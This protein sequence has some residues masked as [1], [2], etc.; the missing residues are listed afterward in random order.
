MITEI[1]QN[2]LF[3]NFLILAASL[4]ILVKAADLIVLGISNYARKF[5]ISEYLIGFLVVSIGMSS[6]EF[7]SSLMGNLQNNS[8]IVLGAFFGAV[9]S[10]LL[11]VVGTVAIFGRKISLE[12]RLLKESRHYLWVLA[13]V[14]VAFMLTGKIPR[15]G[16]GVLVS[17]FAAYV[18]YLW[19]REG[20]FGKLKKDVKIKKFW[21]D[22][23]I[24]LGA[25]VA[26]LLAARWMVFSAVKI[27]ESLHVSSFLV[28]L[29]VIGIS[30]SLPDLSV[31]IRA[32]RKGHTHLAF[33]D[34][35]GSTLCD[36]LLML[37]IVAIV[38]PIVI[39]ARSI[40]LSSIFYLGGLAL[41]LWLIKNR[42]MDYR[43]GILM[44]G[45]YLL[46]IALQILSEAGIL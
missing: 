20:T 41:V 44:I 36:M 19:R 22:V 18:I 4:Y 17:I 29:L 46:F 28:A 32:I 24:F 10:A 40:V 30:S 37:G 25:L 8:G 35:L 39:N 11:L 26:L 13:A 7:V 12:S 34:V 21:K 27:S 31:Q 38:K 14:P 1:F 2:Q 23:L 43:H 16:G 5:G 45:F 9:I 3:I 42:E 15:W 6:P 33:G